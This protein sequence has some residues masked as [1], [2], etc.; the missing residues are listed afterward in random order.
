M[1]SGVMFIATILT[2]MLGQG[3]PPFGESIEVNVTNIDVVV[4]DRSG[5]HVHGLAASDFE[6]Y[7]NGA[8]QPITNFSEYRRA[9]LASETGGEARA[10]E[11]RRPIALLIFVDNLHLQPA[12]RRRALE[13]ISRFVDRHASDPLRVMAVR[14]NG[15]VTETSTKPDLAAFLRDPAYE[16]VHVRERR[17]IMTAIDDTPSGNCDQTRQSVIAFAESMRHDTLAMLDALRASVNSIRGF[18]GRKVVMVLSDGVPQAGGAELFEYWGRRCG[19]NV[20]LEIQQYDLNRDFRRIV[21][22]ANAAG[23]SFY[24]LDA[25]GLGSEETTAVDAAHFGGNRLDASLM[26]DNRRGMLD[27]LA[28]STGGRSI[29]NE[30]VLDTPL[31]AMGDDLRDYYSLGYRTPNGAAL[32]NI[33][34]RVRRDGLQVRARQQYVVMPAQQQIASQIESMFVIAGEDANPLEVVVRGGTVQRDGSHRVLPLAIHVPRTRLTTIGGGRI[35]LYITARDSEGRTAPIR[36]VGRDVPAAGD[37]NET[38][39]L[40]MRRGAHMVVV[41]VRDDVS[42]TLSLVRLTVKL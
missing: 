36:S 10:T 42:G 21:E 38:V 11:V 20:S 9:A 8:L 4:T 6:V 18:D 22:S 5:A 12:A 35:T 40:A 2:W 39:E 26:R 19:S 31:A 24:S 17:R 15:A 37:F 29:K 25:T 34:V 1:T 41:G 27:Y 28:E 13:A 32:H 33:V 7:D 14:F 3:V 23:V 30:N 16:L